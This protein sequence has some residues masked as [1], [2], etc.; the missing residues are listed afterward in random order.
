MTKTVDRVII[1][2]KDI[3]RAGAVVI[4]NEVPTGLNLETRAEA[5]TESG[6]EII[7]PAVNNRYD[8]SLAVVAQGMGLV[9]TG[10]DVGAPL[11]KIRHSG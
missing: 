5:A 4:A 10:Q 7:D 11:A 6:M 1:R 2:E 9:D 8:D 3:W